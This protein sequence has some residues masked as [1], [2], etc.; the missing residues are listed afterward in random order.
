LLNHT[1]KYASHYTEE[2]KEQFVIRMNEKIAQIG[3]KF[4]PELC[5]I[6]FSI[7]ANPVFSKNSRNP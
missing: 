6:F 2:A 1:D 7:Y 3:L 5:K 4:Y